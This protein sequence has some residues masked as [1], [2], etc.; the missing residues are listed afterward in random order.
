MTEAGTADALPASAVPVEADPAE[1]GFDPA[2]LTRID[3]CFDRYVDDGRLPAWQVVVTRHGRVVHGAGRTCP[4]D[5]LWRI[6]SMT[7]PVTSVAAMS[8][9]EE[10]AF[11][12]DTPVAHFIPAFADARVYVR[13]GAPDPLTVPLERPVTMWNLLTHT[14][15]LT[16]GFHHVHPVDELY[17]DAGFEYGTPP[18]LDLEGCCEAWARLPLLFQ[19][20]A[21]WAYSVATDVLGRVIEVIT[22]QPLDEAVTERVLG[23]LGM[24]DTAFGATAPGAAGRLVPLH[25]ADPQTGT[26]VPDARRSAPAKSRPAALSGGSGLVSSAADY[27]RFADMLASGGAHDGGRLLSRATLDAMASN[28]LPGGAD[29]ERFGR[30]LGGVTT[31]GGTGFG[32]GLAVTVDPVAARMPAARGEVSW[33]GAASTWFFVDRAS[34]VAAVFLTQVMPSSSHPELKPLLRTLVAQALTGT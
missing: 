13:G 20:G 11:T 30:P 29:L 12:L 27:R 4:A 21:E 15:G 32:L 1:L 33:S 10:G 18:G 17:R 5:A 9:W 14:A 24:T 23:P 3:R 2:R 34:G 7:K 19:P 8:L 28:Q 22:G 26:A 31:F 6:F 16:Y 25:T